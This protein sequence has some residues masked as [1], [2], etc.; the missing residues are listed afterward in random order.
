MTELCTNHKQ[1]VQMREVI[2]ETAQ[3]GA[4]HVTLR[5][6]ECGRMATLADMS[7]VKGDG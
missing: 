3:N 5:C 6:P 2:R 7:R 1:P 4:V